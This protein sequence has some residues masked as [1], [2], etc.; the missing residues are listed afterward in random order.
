MRPDCKHY[1]CESFVRLV[2]EQGQISVRSYLRKGDIAVGFD[3][4]TS[5]IVFEQGNGCYIEVCG[6]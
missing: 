3:W 6:K 1:Y 5:Y 4:E 2:E